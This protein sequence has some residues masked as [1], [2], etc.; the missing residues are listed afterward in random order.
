[1]SRIISIIQNSG[2]DVQTITTLLKVLGHYLGFDW[3]VANL[4]MADRNAE[5]LLEQI[6][7]T[8][9]QEEYLLQQIQTLS[10]DIAQLEECLISLEHQN[11]DFSYQLSAI[12]QKIV[13]IL[14]E[15][16]YE[17]PG[18][19]GQLD[20]LLYHLN[21]TLKTRNIDL[22]TPLCE[23]NITA[24]I[25]NA[26]ISLVQQIEDLLTGWNLNQLP[27]SERQQ[28]V[29]ALCHHLY[30]IR[31]FETA[32]QYL[33]T[34]IEAGITGSL[35]YYNYFI[36]ALTAR[37]FEV[38]VQGYLTAIQN[39]PELS[40]VPHDR[41]QILRAIDKNRI[42]TIFQGQDTIQ[43]RPVTIKILT[44]PSPNICN[45]IEKSVALKHDG[46]LAVYE[47][48][49]LMAQRPFI[50]QETTNWLALQEFISSAGTLTPDLAISVMSNLLKAMAYSHERGI[51]HGNLI[52]STIYIQPPNI[53]ITDFGVCP[54][55]DQWPIPIEKSELRQIAFVAPELLIPDALPT[56]ASDVYSLG[57]LF[58]FLWT[59]KTVGYASDKKISDVLI[60][61]LAKATNSEPNQRYSNAKEFLEAFPK[62][63][64]VINR[65][66]NDTVILYA[67]TKLESKIIPTNRKI[68][69]SAS[70]TIIL[71]EKF[72]L[73][74]SNV[75]CQYDDSE[76]VLIPCGY[77]IMGSSEHNEEGPVHE[78][79]LNHYLIDKYP[80]TNSQYN[81][82]LEYIRATNDHSRCHPQEPP[83]KNHTPKYW[84]TEQYQ[85]YSGSIDCPVIFVDW[86]DAYSYSVWAGKVL[87]SEAQ[88]EKAARG[89]DGRK[90]PWGDQSPTSEHANFNYNIVAASPVFSHSLGISPYRCFNLAGNVWEWCLDNYDRNFYIQSMRENPV[91]ILNNEAHVARGGAWNSSANHIKATS[92]GCW[93]QTTQAAY[94]GFRCA[95]V[96]STT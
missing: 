88:W 74:E 56:M 77:F 27:S 65:S 5:S 14:L 66:K 51:I 1:M 34:A 17:V 44:G 7:Q 81:Q 76:M 30:S 84:G 53:K 33:V 50:I 70:D 26:E 16:G 61:I 2:Y 13:K 63:S 45:L 80:V 87:P 11:I 93:L 69:L 86:W 19:I 22:N 95:K 20:L 62:S 39:A 4:E 32:S 78:V 47:V 29:L 60:P 68:K 82:F 18:K 10:S 52:P 37:E 58:C 28:V 72:I 73:H 21:E 91:C 35:I 3:S 94:L 49:Q 71:P 38:A 15:L 40:L 8:I 41:Y 9:L 67:S 96:L 89:S 57:I 75:Y 90:Y 42:Q 36:L 24:V 12:R 25:S 43:N 92:R 46:I 59:G 83:Q 54:W 85:Q 48:G 55:E 6:I 31:K 64:E 23:E 79:F